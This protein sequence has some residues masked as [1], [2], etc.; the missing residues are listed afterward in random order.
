M[1]RQMQQLGLNVKLMGGDT[2]CSLE[3]SKLGGDAVGENVLCAQGGALLDKQAS[4]PA[5]RAKYKARFKRD[6]D[7]YAPSFYDQ[8]MFIAESMRMTNSVDSAVVGAQMHKGSYK[9]VVATY[10]YDPM[11]N[12]LKSAVTVYTFRKGEPA[13]VMSY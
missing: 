2:L 11:G 7:V 13:P 6:P 10:A 12:M 4:G 8:M 3:M 1:A 9:G 5:F